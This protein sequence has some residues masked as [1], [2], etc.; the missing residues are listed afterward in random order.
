MFQS[1][2][3][4]WEK[5]RLLFCRR[6]LLLERRRTLVLLWLNHNIT[7]Q[8]F[9]LQWNQEKQSEPSEW[10]TGAD[11]FCACREKRSFT[12]LGGTNTST[13]SSIISVETQQEELRRCSSPVLWLVPSGS[14]E[15]A[16]PR[17]SLTT[18]LPL[19]TEE[20]HLDI[21][22]AEDSTFDR[23]HWSHMSGTGIYRLR[24]TEP[25]QGSGWD[26]LS[27]CHQSH[28]CATLRPAGSQLERRGA[29]SCLETSTSSV[30]KVEINPRRTDGSLKTW[31]RS[32]RFNSS[33]S[34][35]ANS[36]GVRAPRRP[37][38]PGWT[39][40]TAKCFCVRVKAWL[41]W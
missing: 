9:L 24:R 26:G 16:G 5:V 31:R 1:T 4:S 13:T 37:P 23:W 27:D 28:K 38:G 25:G 22:K 6:S 14:M 32:Q 30:A 18:A 21:K 39:V 41:Q 20:N 40:L 10:W 12:R 35:L 8:Y 34:F 11:S 15:A 7:P 17:C 2:N 33:R 3:Q 36:S 29:T 19:R